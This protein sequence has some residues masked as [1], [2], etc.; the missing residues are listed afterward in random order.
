MLRVLKKKII[1]STPR[2]A[3]MQT[4]Q[5]LGIARK[6]AK[7]N[8]VGRIGMQASIG[9][10]APVGNQGVRLFKDH[11]RMNRAR[12]KDANPADSLQRGFSRIFNRAPLRTA[13]SCPPDGV[14]F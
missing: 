14:G 12:R 7:T 4:G 13:G 9:F 8:L 1:A 2:V 10:H 5:G 11:V 6:R 3:G